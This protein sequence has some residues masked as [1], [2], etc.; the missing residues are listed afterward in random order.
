MLDPTY[1][2]AVWIPSFAGMTKFLW[3]SR[4]QW[5]FGLAVAL[6]V[7]FAAADIANADSGLGCVKVEQFIEAIQNYKRPYTPTEIAALKQPHKKWA[8]Q[9]HLERYSLP[10]VFELTW[11]AR[12]AHQIYYK[13][14]GTLP[15]NVKGIGH[16]YPIRMDIS[17][18]G[19]S[20]GDVIQSCPDDPKKDCAGFTWL[21]IGPRVTMSMFL[22]GSAVEKRIAD[23]DVAG[24]LNCLLIEEFADGPSGRAVDDLKQFL[25]GPHTP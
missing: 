22:I 10:N 15:F 25:R 2:S 21:F 1:G 3:V 12:E 7:A 24:S 16:N 9:G 20:V 23:I 19:F 11:N 18:I 17:A 13:E 14:R 4:A 5:L 6:F 8:E